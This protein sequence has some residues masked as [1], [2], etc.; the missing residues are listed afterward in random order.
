MS[1]PSPQNGKAYFYPPSSSQAELVQNIILDDSHDGHSW[2]FFSAYMRK[3]GE[4]DSSQVTLEFWDEKDLISTWLSSEVS[5][6]SRWV[7]ET[8]SQALP[9]K[10]KC[11][12]V[13]L[14]SKRRYGNHN[15]GYYDN[16][17]LRLLQRP[18]N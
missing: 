8:C 13:R 12:V 9:A 15:D 7:K 2:V 11:I 4:S 10:T 18:E 3:Y 16:L 17:M 1:D 14:I 6:C 5:T